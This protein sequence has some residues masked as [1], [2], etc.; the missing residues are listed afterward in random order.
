MGHALSWWSS[1]ISVGSSSRSEIDACN[2][3]MTSFSLTLVSDCGIFVAFPWVDRRWQGTGLFRSFGWGT[4]G[5]RATQLTKTWGTMKLLSWYRKI[6]CWACFLGEDLGILILEL[7]ETNLSS[8][9]NWIS[10]MEQLWRKSLNIILAPGRLRAI[11]PEQLNLPNHASGLREKPKCHGSFFVQNLGSRA[12]L[13]Q[14]YLPSCKH[15]GYLGP[16]EPQH[17]AKSRNIP[18]NH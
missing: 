11:I 17:L 13:S 15:I 8:Y 10:F 16:P 2:H 9:I 4:F 3:R 18:V 14:R 5:G 12:N 6:T 1:S 7:Q